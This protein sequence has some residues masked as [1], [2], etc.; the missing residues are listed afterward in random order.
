M[1]TQR[2]R[3]TNV[4]LAKKVNLKQ[5]V[6]AL[7]VTEKQASKNKI[8]APK[9]AKEVQRDKMPEIVKDSITDSSEEPPETRKDSLLFPIGK[10]S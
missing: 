10:D 1:K 4:S 9:P 7:R 5:D 8:E 6:K 3:K 2:P